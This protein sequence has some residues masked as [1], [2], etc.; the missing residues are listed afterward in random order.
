M[1]KYID[2]VKDMT[3]EDVYA[4]ASARMTVALMMHADMADYFAFL[5]LHGF[6]RLHEYHTRVSVCN[7]NR[8]AYKIAP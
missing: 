4:M 2:K 5:S 7:G 1:N 3:C 8:G 6:K